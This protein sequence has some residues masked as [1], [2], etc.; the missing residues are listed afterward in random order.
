MGIYS[1]YGVE[2]DLHGIYITLLPLNVFDQRLMHTTY[3]IQ[4][5]NFY[6]ENYGSTWCIKIDTIDIEL[7]E[8]ERGLIQKESLKDQGFYDVS[9]VHSTL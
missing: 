5:K 8:L 2:Y 4:R 6:Q 9:R 3:Y 1:E 7:S